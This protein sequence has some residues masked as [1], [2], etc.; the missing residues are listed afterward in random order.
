MVYLGK[1][2]HPHLFKEMPLGVPDSGYISVGES[3]GQTQF[4]CTATLLNVLL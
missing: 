4:T 1:N 3:F 2:D